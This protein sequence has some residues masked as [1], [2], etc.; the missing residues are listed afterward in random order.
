MLGSSDEQLPIHTVEEIAGTTSRNVLADMGAG[1]T[2][3]WTNV[4]VLWSCGWQN[5]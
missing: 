5:F 4:D 2:V 1:E 3:P